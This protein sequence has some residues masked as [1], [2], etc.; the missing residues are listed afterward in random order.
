M[1]QFIEHKNINKKKWD[2]CI[3]S[4]FNSSVFVT[5]WYLDVVCENWCAFVLNDYEAVFP[6][7]IKS[8]YRISYLYQP[9]FARY[10]GVFSADKKWVDKADRFIELIEEKYKYI[11]FCLHESV[12]LIKKNTK[13]KK[14][15]YLE[16][17]SKYAD[18]QKVY[19][20]NALRNI[21]K[22][23]KE[24]YTISNK[25]T[26]KQIVDLFKTTKGGE[27]DIFKPAD[28]KVL[29]ELMDV[30][31][32]KKCGKTIAVIDKDKKIVA[33]A[34][35][36]IFNNKYT[37]LK[38]GVTNFGKQTGAMHLLFDFFIKEHSE[39]DSIL[40]FGGS[41]VDSVARFY[42]NFGAKDC[43]YLHYKINKLPAI[44]KLLKK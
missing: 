42:K 24:N 32:E 25:I 38:S 35:F 16:L 29:T 36:I 14:Y 28:Y 21:K 20:S 3:Y 9:F 33:A 1:I 26:P 8:K 10:F 41:S 4:A 39:S 7:A 5:S 19:S 37:F 6:I 12:V 15:Q 44:L 34:F 30:C 18:I 40:D 31:L 11:D 17:K 23:L 27:L 43:V 2:A 22:A 13:E